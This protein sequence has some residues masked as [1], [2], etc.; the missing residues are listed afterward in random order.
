MIAMNSEHNGA[1]VENDQGDDD[2]NNDR[3]K[4]AQPFDSMECIVYFDFSGVI[5]ES[6]RSV[7]LFV[8]TKVSSVLT[9]I[10]RMEGKKLRGFLLWAML[11]IFEW[12]HHVDHLSVVTSMD[13]SKWT[14]VINQIRRNCHDE[15]GDCCWRC[16]MGAIRIESLHQ[17]RTD[18]DYTT[19]KSDSLISHRPS[20]SPSSIV[21]S[22][23]FIKKNLI[24]WNF[25]F[26]SI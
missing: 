20:P 18:R 11:H 1:I 5:S 7:F 15:D 24:R 25:V 6:N 13:N 9:I 26:N 19:D 12:D 2:L 4:T 23:E 17:H 22:F 3:D 16:W 21:F 8:W 10:S 14:K